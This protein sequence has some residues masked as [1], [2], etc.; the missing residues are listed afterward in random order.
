MPKN[1][2]RKGLQ[3]SEETLNFV[4]NTYTMDST[5]FSDIKEIARRVIPDNGQTC[6]P[7]WLSGSW[8]FPQRV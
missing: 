3:Y 6:N 5:I 2:I 7:F 8:R 1:K 4:E